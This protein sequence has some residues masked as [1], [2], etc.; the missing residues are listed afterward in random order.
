VQN[1]LS[2]DKYNKNYNNI[3]R[4]AETYNIYGNSEKGAMTPIPLANALSNEFPAIVNTVR[5]F[6]TDKVSISSGNKN[7]YEDKV[8]LTDPSILKVFTLPII[9]GNANA[10]LNEPMTVC[11]TQNT[12]RKYFGNKEAVGKIIRFD[13]KYNLKV[14]G[15]L[16]NIPSNSHFHFNL[17]ISMRSAPEIYGGNF[18]TNNTKVYSY[19]LLKNRKSLQGI[20]NKLEPFLK[21]YYNN[22]IMYNAFKPSISLQ[23]LST[24]HLYSNIGSELESNG[25]I[26]YVYIFSA[27]AILVL[28][29]ACINYMNIL[30][31]RYSNRIKE[32]G[33]RKVLGAD[34]PNLFKQFF[35]ESCLIALISLILAIAITELFLPKINSILNIKLS[36]NFFRNFGLL[37][38]IIISV[39]IIGIIAG[40]YPAFLLSSFNPAKIFRVTPYDQFSSKFIIK[41]LVVF[42]F[43]ISTGIIISS[44]VITKQLNF[45]QNKKLGLDKENIVILP[46]REDYTRKHYKVLKNTILKNVD[47]SSVTASSV[48]PGDVKGFTSVKWN[49]SSYNKTMDFILCDYDFIKSFKIKLLEGRD[50]SQK[51]GTDTKKA[52]LLNQ[53][54]VE[55]IGWKNPI[56][57]SFISSSLGEG[58]VIGVVKD[59]NYKSLQHAIKPLFIAIAPDQLNYI[60]IRIKANKIVPGL[61]YIKS[62]WKKIFPQSPYEYSF[63]DKHLDLLYKSDNKL[64]SLFDIFSALAIVIASLGLYGLASISTIKK[65]KEI[66]IRKILGASNSSI[67]SIIFKEFILLVLL[68]NVLAWPIVWLGMNKWLQAFAYKFQLNIWPFLIVTFCLVVASLIIISL[69]AIKAATA[70]P[71][72]SLRYE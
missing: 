37:S 19:I 3:Y 23:P 16:K 44:V 69:R 46:L 13:N 26:R 14:T 45:I 36:L 27:I 21:K 15:V 39:S 64:S 68:A 29:M 20:E 51:Y 60:I 43:L 7:F 61:D 17:L 10:L 42:Q 34:R 28:L 8:F 32:V 18:F 33:I 47:I 58:K 35:V 52:Y 59:F 56:G 65:T 50:F 54:A 24:I 41:I 57:Q 62:S 49:G 72:K 55:E 70:N 66:G 22:G 25:D 63:F 4:I 12:A 6:K 5:L 38:L 31:A 1:Q 53:S 40:S 48:L 71:V 9:Q 11:I 30:T 67:V 2:Y